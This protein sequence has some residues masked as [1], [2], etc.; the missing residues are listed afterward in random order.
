MNGGQLHAI[1][2]HEKGIM[3][4]VN[5]IGEGV[6]FMVLGMGTVF[7]FL[8]ILILAMNVMSRIITRYFPEP[9]GTSV[10]KESSGT[11]GPDLK[12]VAAIAGAIHHHNK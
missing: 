6:K 8:I 2:T 1:S 3:M 4:E 7:V 11:K 9:Q 10:Q 5:L 12:K